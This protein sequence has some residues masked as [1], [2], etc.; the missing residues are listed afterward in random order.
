MK[1]IYLHQYF[2]NDEMVGGTRSFEFAKRLVKKGHEVIIITSSRDIEVNSRITII[3][4]I[5]VYWLNV[6][7][8]N[9]MNNT[10]RIISFLEFSIKSLLLIIK[11]K[12]DIIF[13][14]ST[15]LTISIPAI[16]AS[17]LRGI[18]FVFEVR[19][20]WP[21][22]PIAI[23]ALRNKLTILLAYKLEKWTYNNSNA[24]IAL[25][26]GIKKEIM[27]TGYDEN[28]IVVIPNS[29]DVYNFQNLNSTN[30]NEPKIFKII[31][32]FKERPLLL[33][34]GTF[35]LINECVYAIDLAVELDRLKSNIIILLIGE[36]AEYNKLKSM[37]IERKVYNN[38]LF[39]ERG[40]AKKYMP[41]LFSKCKMSMI[42]FKDIPEMQTNSSNKFFDS[43]AAGKPVIINFGGWMNDIV[44]NSK[45]GLAVWRI[46]I[47]KVAIIID[48]YINNDKKIEY[49]SKAALN[50]ANKYY[51]RSELFL[52]FEELLNCVAKNKKIDNINKIS[53]EKYY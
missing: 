16:I 17:K 23:G 30:Q 19:D 11:I 51:N 7:Y 14:T 33:Y 35:G 22:L 47:E 38:N 31:E 28:K 53:L 15:P 4:G 48:K 45:C 34:A 44:L 8:S 13:A 26:P 41:K 43:L 12:S 24:I 20:I 32:E 6:K 39:I 52:K 37:A 18:P 21:L 1:I 40:I 5:K 10:R 3:E 29:C 42:L 50:L 9:N 46:P 27:K 49:S 36:G 25:S 2:N